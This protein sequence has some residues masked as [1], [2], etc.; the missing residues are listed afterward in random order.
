MESGGVKGTGSNA[1]PNKI[2]LTPE[3]EKYYRIKI[4]EAK[5]RGIIRKQITLGIIVIVK[6]Q[7]SL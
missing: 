5:A 1:N 6:K 2:K 3:R 7:K 4:D